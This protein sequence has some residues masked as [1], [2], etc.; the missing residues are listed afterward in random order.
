M[1]RKWTR[2]FL[3]LFF[4]AL[5]GTLGVYYFYTMHTKSL[6]T[7]LE[8]QFVHSINDRDAVTATALFD[9]DGVFTDSSGVLHRGYSSIL[10]AIERLIASNPHLSVASSR[11]YQH[12]DV[13]LLLTDF[14]LTMPDETPV[15][16]RASSVLRR[17]TEGIWR[18][19]IMV[20]L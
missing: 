18:Y 14:S 8:N 12:G 1:M 9:E 13:M 15:L 5:L 6:P 16:W 10:P 7:Y 17:N 19:S 4:L 2:F 11:F 3:G 20:F